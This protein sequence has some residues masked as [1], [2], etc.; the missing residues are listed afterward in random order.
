MRRLAALVAASLLVLVGSTGTAAAHAK[1]ESMTPSDGSTVADPPTS[2]VLRFNEPVGGT[3]AEIA[4]TAPSGRNFSAGRPAV[5]DGTVT[6]PLAVLTE[7]GRYRVSVRIVSADGHPITASASFSVTHPGHAQ[8]GAPAASA[9]GDGD[10]SRVMIVAM[11]LVMLVV[12]ALAVV[13]VRRRPVPE[14]E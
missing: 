10:S 4:V 8:A 7:A 13:I 5:V 14:S 3:G 11:V 9:P 12:V 2:L 6:Q 1:L